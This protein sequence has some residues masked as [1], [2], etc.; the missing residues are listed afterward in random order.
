MNKAFQQKVQFKNATA[1]ELFDIFLNPKK[2]AA[3]HGGAKTKISKKEGDAFSLLNGHLNG[4]NLMIVPDRMIVQSWRGNVW[5]R[6]LA[7]IIDTL[8]LQFFK[9]GHDLLCQTLFI[10]A[11]C[12]GKFFCLGRNGQ[13]LV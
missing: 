1:A 13:I 2:H 5:Q 9:S 4:K 11:Q 6:T 12:P 10:F 7:P 3:I 8:A